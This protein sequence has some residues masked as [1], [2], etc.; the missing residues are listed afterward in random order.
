MQGAFL[1]CID[2]LW[3]TK[4]GAEVPDVPLVVVGQEIVDTRWE[5]H[6][7]AEYRRGS[8]GALLPSIEEANDAIPKQFWRPGP[9]GVGLVGP[10]SKQFYVWLFNP[11]NGAMY[12]FANSTVGAERAFTELRNATVWTGRYRQQD[13]AAVVR[14]SDAP[15]PTRHG[16]K[17]RP[18]FEIV[19][20]IVR[21]AGD[22]NKMVIPP[23]GPTPQLSGP[24]QPPK[25]APVEEADDEIE[26]EIFDED[27]DEVI[28][29]KPITRRVTRVAKK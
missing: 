29:T 9:N 23:T 16:A 10:W 2:G 13:L 1:K 24:V 22:S 11:A 21:W 12:T 14:L 18:A 7:P 26:D 17:R 25:T 20:F 28:V 27:E 6:G 19:E 4:T 15:M 8:D 5:D 3:S